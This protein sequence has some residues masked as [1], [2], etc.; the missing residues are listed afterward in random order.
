MRMRVGIA[1]MSFLVMGAKDRDERVRDILLGD[2]SIT[3]TINVLDV[4]SRNNY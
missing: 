2:A 3:K 1:G 4:L